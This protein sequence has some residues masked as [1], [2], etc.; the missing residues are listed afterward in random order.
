MEPATGPLA[1]IYRFYAADGALLY[2]GQST[3]AYERVR[4]HAKGKDWFPEASSVTF[5]RVPAA[6]VLRREAEAIR[7]ERPRYNIVHRAVRP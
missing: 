4:Q 5:E 2:I 3:K 7:A 1:T 6:E